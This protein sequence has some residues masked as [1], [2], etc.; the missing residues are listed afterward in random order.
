[1]AN[2]L[3]HKATASDAGW[4]LPWM[5]RR[6]LAYVYKI[7]YKQKLVSTGCMGM[8]SGDPW[9]G[10]HGL[11]GSMGGLTY[12]PR[13]SRPARPTRPVCTGP[14]PHAAPPG[15]RGNCTNR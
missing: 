8:A 14:A 2:C 4:K 11:R 1:M 7:V 10:I 5:R 6:L 9:A 15:A 13:P 3:W 12:A